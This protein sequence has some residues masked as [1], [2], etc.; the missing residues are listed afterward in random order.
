MK[1]PRECDRIRFHSKKNYHLKG[2][3]IIAQNINKVKLENKVM[4]DKNQTGK[5]GL[6]YLL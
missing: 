3:I 1:K 5:A 4:T 6:V 2:A